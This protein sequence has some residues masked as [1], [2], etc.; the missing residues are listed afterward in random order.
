MEFGICK[1]A[2]IAAGY[3]LHQQLINAQI[4]TLLLSA[5]DP[6]EVSEAELMEKTKVRD[7]ENPTHR[8][9]LLRQVGHFRVASNLTMSTLRQGE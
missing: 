6:T 3:R 1:Q 8:D 7:S 2:R 9:M 4:H 5:I